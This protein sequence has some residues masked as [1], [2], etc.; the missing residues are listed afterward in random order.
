MDDNFST[1]LLLI[2][3]ILKT[4]F[5]LNIKVAIMWSG[6]IND[7]LSNLAALLLINYLMPPASKSLEP[8]GYPGW[9]ELWIVHPLTG[10]G[11]PALV[12]HAV[13]KNFHF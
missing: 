13:M 7:K 4:A 11:Q 3:P 2:K 10:A 9:G 12:L 1:C 5:Y 6:Q 8:L